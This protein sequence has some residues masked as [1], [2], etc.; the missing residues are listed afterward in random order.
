MK[1]LKL[2]ILLI[3]CAF[4]LISCDT[5]MTSLP[6]AMPEDFSF[7]LTFGFDYIKDS[8]EYKSLPPNQNIYE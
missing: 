4:Y 7:T 6:K 2:K 8:E 3:I 1:K 5:N